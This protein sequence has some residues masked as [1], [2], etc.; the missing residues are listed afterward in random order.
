MPVVEASQAIH[1]SLDF[2]SVRD[3]SHGRE[4]QIPRSP[5]RGLPPPRSQ[6]CSSSLSR[7]LPAPGHL[8]GT[9]LVSVLRG[10]SQQGAV[11]GTPSGPPEALILLLGKPVS[12]Y[13]EKR[14]VLQGALRGLS[15]ATTPGTLGTPSPQ[16]TRA[17]EAPKGR[18]G[19][20]AAPQ[21]RPCPHCSPRAGLPGSLG[22][23]LSKAAPARRGLRS[24]WVGVAQARCTPAPALG[25]ALPLGGARG[26]LGRL[27]ALDLGGPRASRLDQH[28][29]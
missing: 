9:Y 16:N 19:H 5:E 17:E 21:L 28:R 1:G 26:H 24:L 11:A 29:P 20:V 3:G 23:L 6:A 15:S 4:H 10:L 7:Q 22:P 25:T 14:G 18:R 2:S 13:P 12:S 27:R 8:W